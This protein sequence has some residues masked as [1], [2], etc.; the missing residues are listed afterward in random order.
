LGLLGFAGVLFAYRTISPMRRRRKEH[1]AGA[2]SADWLQQQ[3]GT[4]DNQ[5]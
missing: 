3:R 2:V 4:R 1:D 5:H